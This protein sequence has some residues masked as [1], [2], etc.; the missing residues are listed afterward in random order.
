MVRADVAGAWTG[1]GNDVRDGLGGDL[2][3]VGTRS[4]LRTQATHGHGRFPARRCHGANRTL[5]RPP[6]LRP[7]L[8]PQV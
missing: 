6:S 3:I 5:F 8:T 4:N 7:Y 2:R 1:Q